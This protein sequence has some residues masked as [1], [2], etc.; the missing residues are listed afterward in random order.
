[1]QL[2]DDALL[3]D[4][5][6][7]A[8]AVHGDAHYGARHVVVLMAVFNGAAFLEEQL[9]S[10]VDQAHR[11]WSL[12][13]SDDGSTDRS[14]DILQDFA[15][16]H[17]GRRVS[18]IQGP[19]AGFAQNFLALVRAA[20][21]RAPFIAFCDQDDVW[22]PGKLSRALDRM[23]KDDRAV[24]Y[25]GRTELL[26]QDGRSVGLS[27][28]FRRP[29]AFQ[30]ALVQSIAGGNTMV[31]NRAGLSVLQRAARDPIH[32]VSHDWWAYQVISGAGGCVHYDPDPGVLYRQHDANLVG[33]NTGARA[34][35][36]RLRRLLAGE[37]RDWTEANLIALNAAEA[38]L[39]P[40][41]R[42]LL[43]RFSEM[44]RAR[45]IGRVRGIWR[46][47]LHRQTRMGQLALIAA[48]MLRK[49]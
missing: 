11:D 36:Q 15:R 21:P 42:D 27:P 19:R 33:A 28:L 10:L 9:Q 46:L 47:G 18:V 41:N 14:L 26:A 48:A 20:D 32:V 44:R 40:E 34:R 13:V 23:G 38:V 4:H 1:M 31:L 35:L 25:G 22:M 2:A 12:L 5:R 8:T 30:N 16:A 39:T 17:P 6:H 7:R 37:L 43:N 24:L 49:I 29:P 45:A 3:I